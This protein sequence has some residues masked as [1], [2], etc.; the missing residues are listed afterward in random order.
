[1]LV[2]AGPA[3]STVTS[4]AAVIVRIRRLLNTSLSGRTDGGQVRAQG[5]LKGSEDVDDSIVLS[6]ESNSSDSTR[7]RR[8]SDY[9]FSDDGP[10]ERSAGDNGGEDGSELGEHG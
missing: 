2:R 8:T 3:E 1:M 10:D 9:W 7:A 4:A 6:L 5:R